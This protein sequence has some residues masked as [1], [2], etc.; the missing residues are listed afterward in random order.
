MRINKESFKKLYKTGLVTP[1][2]AL[3]Y[4]GS[5]FVYYTIKDNKSGVN[6]LNKQNRKAERSVWRDYLNECNSKRQELDGKYISFKDSVNLVRKYKL[7][8]LKQDYKNKLNKLE[9]EL[10]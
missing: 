8:S 5:L 10:K 4:L 1:L 6:E 3:I 2:V 7:D 9:K